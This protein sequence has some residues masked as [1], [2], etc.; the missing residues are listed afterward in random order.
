LFWDAG[1]TVDIHEETEILDVSRQDDGLFLTTSRGDIEGPFDRVVLAT[2][3]TFPDEGDATRSYF[4]SSW[5]GLIEAEIPTVSV[6][7]P[8]WKPIGRTFGVL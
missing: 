7:N 1:T 5:S 2:G 8:D 3:H 6:G 4:P